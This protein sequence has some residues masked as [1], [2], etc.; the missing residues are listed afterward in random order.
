MRLP[1]AAGVL[2]HP[3]SLPGPHGSGD[4]GEDAYHFIDWLQAAGQ[5][6]W[7]ILPLGG[8]GPGNSPYMSSS[9]FAGNELMINLIELQHLG[10]LSAA[11]TASDFEREA[12]QVDFARMI[13]YRMQRLALAAANF[14]ASGDTDQK[15][16]F[17][18]FCAQQ[19]HW[20][21]D[22]AL[23]MTLS[24][25]FPG[26]SWSD[27]DA[28]LAR[29]D[30]DAL[31][32]AVDENSAAV[33][34]WK[35]CQWCFFR[36][37]GNLRRYANERGIRI[38]GDAPIFIA[39][40]SVEAWARPELFELDAEGRLKVIAGVPPDY[41]SATGQRWG[42]P[43]YRWEAHQAED[44]SWWIER[45]RHSLGMV[46]ILRIDHFIGFTRYWEIPA[47]EP[48]AEHGRWLPA[49][50]EALLD[51]LRAALG[52]MPIIAEDLGS[53]TAEVEALRDKFEL[54]GMC[55]M[56]FAWGP[57]G[58]PRFLP[59]NHDRNLVV[60]TGTHDNDT[61]IGWWHNADEAQR[62]HLRDY[63]ATSAREVN[64]D[65][66]RCVMAS[67][68]DTAIIPLQDLLGLDSA[69]R[70]N[71]PGTAEN[72]WTWRMLWADLAGDLAQQMLEQCHLYGRE[73]RA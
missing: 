27:W 3:T 47:S 66:V 15:A 22:Y 19:A 26:R 58:N 69:H 72:N 42:N 70:L 50:G 45:I 62:Q 20:L 11:E 54:P 64:R 2:L 32:R 41:F 38:I 21:D 49:P 17:D 71:L 52:S 68:A 12:R 63:L 30:A 57:D 4:F 18:S 16:Q 61:S 5:S 59:H 48:T 28:A 37:W 13:P 39:Y 8:I 65:L 55:V 10:W 23:F 40:D 9:A 6:Y 31:E 67:V 1:R 25:R 44:F 56:H 53:V 33:H 14:A 34:L 51:A 73:R 35:F 29:R 24:K 36:Q 46:D 60:Y 43:L 7:Q